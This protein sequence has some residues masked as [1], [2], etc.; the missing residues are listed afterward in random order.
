MEQWGKYILMLSVGLIGALYQLF[1]LFPESRS[2]LK[3]DLEIL[4]M[5][6]SS[7]PNYLIVKKRIDVKIRRIYQKKVHDTFDLVLGI[8]FFIAFLI[9]TIYLVKD[10]FSWWSIVTGFFALVGIGMIS[11]AFDQSKAKGKEG[12]QFSTHKPEEA[13]D[14]TQDPVY[15][16]EGYDSEAP[17]DLSVNFDKYF[18]GEKSTK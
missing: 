2:T 5:L 7:D 10:S 1:K 18:Y 3:N 14:I 12:E 17:K 13:F 15:Q 8:I 9:W 4:G 16:M 6:E 11:N